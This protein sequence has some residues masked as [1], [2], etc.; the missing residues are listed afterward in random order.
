MTG[1][2]QVLIEDWC[3]QYPSHSIGIARVRRRRR[4]LRERRRRRELQLRRLRP[5]RQPAQPVRRP[6][7]RR[8]RDADAADRRGRRAAQP[9]PADDRATRVA[10]TARSCASTRR[11]APA[12]PTTRSRVSSDPNARRIIAHGFRNP[13]R[14]TVRPGHE[15]GLGRRRRLEHWEEIDRRHDPP[16]RRSRTSAGRATRARPPGRLRRREP[17]TSARPSTRSRPARSR[18][19]STPTTTLPRSSRARRCPT[20]SSSIAGLAFYDAAA[21]YPAAYDGALFFADYSRDCIWAMRRA[22]TGSRPGDA[23]RPSPP[24]RPTRSTCRSGRTATS[25]TSTSTA[26]RSAGSRP[27]EAATPRRRRFRWWRLRRGKRCPARSRFRPTAGDNVGVAGVQFKVDGVNAAS[28]ITV[29]AVLL[30]L[31]HRPPSRTVARPHSDG[32]RCCWE[33]HDE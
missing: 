32:P 21:N 17:D 8:R 24:A 12:C 5:G 26:A 13:F 31:E 22:A 1:T 18:A 25:T 2:E 23:C 4:A 7:R 29:A 10:W 27:S 20:G 30:R 33:H 16:D 28:E 14:I 9:G 3:Q 15:R 11:R 6:A 19:R